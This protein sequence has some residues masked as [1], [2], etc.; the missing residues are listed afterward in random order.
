LFTLF[1]P[2]FAGVP[3]SVWFMPAG[4]SNDI[5]SLFS[6]PN[7]W[8]DA[9]SKIDG[10][11][12]SP[13]QLDPKRPLFP[14]LKHVDAFRK[15]NAWHLKT[16]IAVPAIKEWDCRA[17]RTPKVTASM[18][19]TVYEAGGKVDFLQTDDALASALAVEH[20]ACHLDVA[21]AVNV[22]TKYMTAIRADRSLVSNGIPPKVADVE[23]YPAS[24]A[25]MLEQWL[26]GLNAA[27]VRPDAFLLDVNVH[28]IDRSQDLSSKLPGDLR[29]LKNRAQELG[30]QFGII[31]WSGYNPLKSNEEY[32][33]H[34]MKWAEAIRSDIGT[35]YRLSFASWVRRCG[36]HGNCIGPTLGCEPNDAPDCGVVSVPTNLPAADNKENYSHTRLI[37][38]VLTLFNTN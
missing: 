5:T 38:D 32:Y 10:F 13:G 4:N 23:A 21:G 33:N 26:S 29:R 11:I 35:P 19:R 14:A 16:I 17:D 28:A 31:I 12:F 30:I 24:N 3:N 15:V 36:K 7:A 6:E 37:K 20:S 18:A 27:G 25:A 34:A 2:A 22:M 8:A 9:R 1:G